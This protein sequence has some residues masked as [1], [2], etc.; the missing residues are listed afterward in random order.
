M[1]DRRKLITPLPMAMLCVAL[2]QVS[3]CKPVSREVERGLVR[4]SAHALTPAAKKAVDDAARRAF[5]SGARAGERDARAAAEEELERVFRKGLVPVS[6]EERAKINSR[7]KLAAEGETDPGRVEEIEKETL[8]HI[9][10]CLYGEDLKRAVNHALDK[11]DDDEGKQ[12]DD[13][14]RQSDNASEPGEGGDCIGESPAASA[15]R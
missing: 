6:E 4:K 8:H 13:E 5:A 3:G 2:L 1:Q 14:G 12:D 9:L 15:P 7:I 11:M 10:E